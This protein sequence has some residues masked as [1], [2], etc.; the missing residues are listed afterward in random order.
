MEQRYK[1]TIYSKNIYREIEFL[2]GMER[3]KLGTTLE[4]EVRL[5]KE[6]FFEEFEI[7]MVKN[8]ESWV[9]QT[10]ENIYLDF[11][12]NRKIW[13]KPL[14][15][16]EKFQVR[17]SSSGAVLFEGRFFVDFDYENKHYNRVIDISGL[18]CLKIGA[19][20]NAHLQIQSEYVYDDVLELHREKNKMYLCNFRSQYGVFL[21]GKGIES[22][23]ELKNYDFFS[24]A[25]FSFYYKAGKLFLDSTDKIQ[26]RNISYSD[27]AVNRDPFQYPEF[28]RSSRVKVQLNEEEI[29]ILVPKD[30]PQKPKSQLLLRILPALMMV[31]LMIVMRF[32]SNMNNISY[33]LF[34]V[35][36]VSVGAFISVFT[37][38]NAKKEYQKA[39]EKRDVG[40]RNYIQNKKNEII[41]Y[42]EEERDV[43]NEL[44]YPFEVTSSFVHSFSGNLFD[45]TPE[46]SDFL[47]VR[48]G[49]GNVEALR[50]ITVKTQ[51]TY[52]V[53]D[54]PLVALPMQLQNEEREIENSPIVLP[55]KDVSAVGIVGSHDNLY[56][57]M[58]IIF[59]D[60]TIRQYYHDVKAVILLPP[61]E[62]KKYEWI[63]WSHHLEN[64]KIL[65]RNIVCD[66]ESKNV[67][68]EY[69]YAEI[70]QREEKKQSSPHIVIFVL[71]D[72]DIQQHPISKYIARAADVG[73]TFLFFEKAKEFVPVGARYLIGLGDHQSGVMLHTENKQIYSEFRYAP[74]P[75]Q[76]MFQMSHYL[77]PVYCKETSLE[78]S[79]TKNI[80]LFQ[81]LHIISEEDL[82]LNSRWSNS[83]VTKNMAAPIGVKAGSKI[84]ALD[85]HDGEKAHGPHGLVA[86][87]TG[88]GKSEILMTY[89]LSMATLYHPYEVA[90]LIIDFKGGGMA[91]QF[92]N[93]PHT[94]G[95]ITD[96]DGKEINRSLISIKAELDRRKRLFAIAGV[97]HIDKYI[98]V[99]KAGKIDVALPHL[100]IIVDEFAELKAM[101]PDFMSELIS[102]ARIGRS[103]G[104]HLILATQKPSGQVSDQIWSN[105][106]FRLCL[107]VQ[108]PEDSK[109]VIKSPLASEI[110]EAGRAYLMVG[111]NE[112]FELFQSAYSGAAANTDESFMQKEFS[113]S[114]VNLSGKRTVIYQRKKKKSQHDS[115]SQK[116]AISNWIIDYCQ[117]NQIEKLPDICKPPLP[118][119]MDYHASAAEKNE[120]RHIIC[121]IGLY[122]NPKEQVQEIH[123]VD[124]ALSHMLIIGSSQSGKTNLQQLIL[125]DLATNY[126]PKEVIFYVI[127]FASM[128]FRNMKD[129]AHVGGVVTP[130]DDERMENLFKLLQVEISHRKEQLLQK[131]CSSFAAYREAGYTDMPQ[132]V[133]L[134]DNL[135]ALK[136]T[137]FK[138]EDSRL[139]TILRDG[140][141]SGISVIATNLQATG[142]NYRYMTNFHE[143]ISFFCNDNA[144]YAT[145]F[146]HCKEKLDDISGRCWVERENQI[147]ECQ[148]YLAF[149]G[150]RESDR[151][152]AIYSFIEETN[153]KY[154]TESALPI[155]EVAEKI[156]AAACLSQ[157]KGYLQKPFDV[158]IGLD[159]VS[160]APYCMNLI[161]IGLFAVLGRFEAERTNFIKYLI[162]ALQTIY[163]EKSQV[164]IA[165]DVERQL[166]SVRQESN[167]VQ[168]SRNAEDIKSMLDE[169]ESKLADR[170]QRFSEGEDNAIEEAGLIL[171]IVQNADAMQLAATDRDTLTKYQNIRTRYKNMR[172]C[173]LVSC[174]ENAPVSFSAPEMLRNIKDL[175]QAVFFDD[176][177]NL[178]LFDVPFQAAKQFRKKISAND[179]YVIQDA[180]VNKI[181][182]PYDCK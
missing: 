106:K 46:D 139:L 97:D 109:E 130:A 10:T 26:F 137:Y 92:K 131:G 69:L 27:I 133:L 48:I 94:L 53:D 176:I 125:R 33:M 182:A 173:I 116:D 134:I 121:K 114:K 55:L 24:I 120:N 68:F 163:P 8:N 136:D 82:D 63:K 35:C 23:T 32:V 30:K 31:I 152:A 159:Y 156:P 74:I 9:I 118:T 113:I 60:L 70:N 5:R 29:P 140:I 174:A 52:E 11:G 175:R 72:Y 119:C 143:K 28:H 107:K 12:G 105:T 177:S 67:V 178:K 127:D 166:E 170:Y 71:H 3:L 78:S 66:E 180:I 165:D 19:A 51:E 122:D 100:I 64:D 112:I 65:Y 77:A 62:T 162:Y 147:L 95:I 75:D 25:N 15:H 16:G 150:E 18:P 128:V 103:L 22:N 4:S 42:R 57:M 14:E 39:V 126:G 88:S 1:L 132:I 145:L 169:I 154:P 50:K 96:I 2:P 49:T 34:S 93:L 41:A 59:F 142:L 172:V 117:K 17:Y 115:I 43:L 99:Y 54:D 91:N 129:L 84:V 144:E 101:F 138:D 108:T 58:K 89:I 86:G 6:F 87:T 45:R 135:T 102:A 181:K 158:P 157:G 141:S 160:V 124:L 21:N 56:E 164:Y 104:V 7:T 83:D 36:S 168:Y 146:G 110:K 167:V 81:L 98:R 151:I 111:N 153:A 149:S 38:I 171:L 61:T 148:T 44:Y 123:S 80:T 40:Y 47:S 90:F 20:S 79:L 179:C 13:T 85:I 155:P 76:Q 161:K 73:I 37:T